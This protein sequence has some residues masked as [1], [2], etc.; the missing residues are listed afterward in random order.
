MPPKKKQKVSPPYPPVPKTVLDKIMSVCCEVDK[1][2][3]QAIKKALANKYNYTNEG[4]INSALTQGVK[5]GKLIQKG[6]S[7]YTPGSMPSE[8]EPEQEKWT[9]LPADDKHAPGDGMNG[10]NSNISNGFPEQ[11]IDC[12]RLAENR[13]F[14]KFAF[15]LQE[16]VLL[17]RELGDHDK[18]DGFLKA[19][20]NM[21]DLS[22]NDYDDQKK[23]IGIGHKDMVTDMVKDDVKYLRDIH[24]VGAS[25]VK[26]IEEWIETGTMKRLE[27]LRKEATPSITEWVRHKLNGEEKEEAKDDTKETVFHLTF[28]Y[29]GK[30][31]TVDG[32]YSE[33]YR[34]PGSDGN[35]WL[36]FDGA[37]KHGI[38]P[39][40]A[41]VTGDV[42]FG[43]HGEGCCDLE[44]LGDGKFDQSEHSDEALADAILKAFVKNAPVSTTMNPEPDCLCPLEY[45]ELKE[46]IYGSEKEEEEEEE[47]EEFEEKKD[48][49]S[50]IFVLRATARGG[51]ID[52][53]IPPGARLASGAQCTFIPHRTATPPRCAVE[54][55]RKRTRTR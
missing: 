3:R 30:T 9:P 17:Y 8:Y 24:C 50:T 25:T 47:E 40:I 18:G 49:I 55:L 1:P 36:H 11:R 4:A 42:Y 45:G 14:W 41:K 43:C 23:D 53:V 46:R 29:D 20:H 16:L 52:G 19:L 54:V 6:Q 7:F 21:I 12:I 31:Y 32:T 48:C 10:M 22:N 35:T 13:S 5:M 2:S 27:D 15:H 33:E 26:L 37:L 39:S 44:D 51:T 28:E 34:L 38:H